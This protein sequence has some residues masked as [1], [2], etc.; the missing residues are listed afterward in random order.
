M[1]MSRPRTTSTHAEVAN[2][3]NYYERLVNESIL[4]TDT[5]AVDD[6]DFLADVSCVALNHLPPRYIRHDVDMSFFMSPIEREETENKVQTAVDYA[7]VFVKQHEDERQEI[8]SADIITDAVDSEED[9]EHAIAAEEK[10]NETF[11]TSGDNNN[12]NE[13]LT[14]D[15]GVLEDD[16]LETNTAENDTNS[17]TDVADSDIMADSTEEP[18]LADIPMP[19]EDDI[20]VQVTMTQ[21]SENKPDEQPSL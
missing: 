13:H 11:P 7:L 5:R 4:K 3:H 8:S 20:D 15:S 21:P 17:D 1:L 16:A 14:V 9:M 2:V 6:A 10:Q 19:S 18:S 12:N